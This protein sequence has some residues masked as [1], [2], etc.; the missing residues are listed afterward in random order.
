[1]QRQ[2]EKQVQDVSRIRLLDGRPFI[3]HNAHLSNGARYAARCGVCTATMGQAPGIVEIEVP[4]PPVD[5]GGGTDETEAAA[6][7]H[8][9]D[10]WNDIFGEPRV[11]GKEA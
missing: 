6:P 10:P 11:R 7:A 5:K 9:R 3:F 4:Q 2:S 1:M 8:Y